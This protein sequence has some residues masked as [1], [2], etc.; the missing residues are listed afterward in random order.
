MESLMSLKH[1][2]EPIPTFVSQHILVERSLS[3]QYIC[4]QLL[5]GDA[6]LQNSPNVL[7]VTAQDRFVVDTVTFAAMFLRFNGFSMVF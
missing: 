3:D 4:E 6:R 5:R 2:V 1:T 7:N